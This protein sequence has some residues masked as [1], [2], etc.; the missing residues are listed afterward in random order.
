LNIDRAVLA[1]KLAEARSARDGVVTG[2]AATG[3]GPAGAGDPNAV[4]EL[5]T[6]LDAKPRTITGRDVPQDNS[7]HYGPFGRDSRWIVSNPYLPMNRR[8]LPYTWTMACTADGSVYLGGESVVPALEWRRQPRANLDWY[9]NN[10]EGVWKVALDG[11]ITAFGVRPYGNSLRGS[12]ETAKC[13]VNVRDAGI[14]V[15]HWGG[16][17]VDA[18]GDVLFSDSDLHTIMKLRRDGVVEHVAGGGPMACAYERYKV[19]QKSGYQDGPAKQ[20]LFNAPRGLALGR[21]GDLFVAD[22]GNCALRRI[23][24]AGNVTTV[25]K[26]SCQFDQEKMGFEY[27]A[28]DSEG[29][30]I[31]AGVF[32]LMGKEIYSG[33]YRFHADGRIEALLKGRQIAP[34]TRQQYVGLLEGL[35]V[36][37]DGAV[38]ISDGF[39][40]PDGGHLLQ[41]RGGGVTRYLGATSDNPQQPE[42]DG[43]A[44]KAVLFAPGGLC[45]SGDGSLF[46]QPHHSLRPVRKYDPRGRT[47]TTWVY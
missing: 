36:L 22:Q 13:G 33:V 30:P 47:V 9:A 15:E 4:V 16:M 44:D 23:D 26:R 1:Q 19:N 21:N 35:V 38:V 2:A 40:G 31:V 12:F 24:R 27:V 32:G 46:I 3:V 43:A 6:L 42:I 34:Q 17:A 37:P 11:R 7:Q 5:T 41:V 18:N 45:A 14:A 29:L 28:I 20:A 10:S 39:E 8:F 25:G